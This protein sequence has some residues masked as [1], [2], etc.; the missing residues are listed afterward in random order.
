M[1]LSYSAFAEQSPFSH[2]VIIKRSTKDTKFQ[3]ATDKIYE[4]YKNAPLTN[5]PVDNYS[6]TS[7]ADTVK[8][9]PKNSIYDYI[10]IMLENDPDFRYIHVAPI[11]DDM[12]TAPKVVPKLSVAKSKAFIRPSPIPQKSMFSS[13]SPL[14]NQNAS[15]SSSSVRNNNININNIVNSGSEEDEIEMENVSIANVNQSNGQSK[16]RIPF[17]IR[18]IFPDMISDAMKIIDTAEDDNAITMTES[19]DS[20]IRNIATKAGVNERVVDQIEN[21]YADELT[22]DVLVAY[23]TKTLINN[24]NVAQISRLNDEKI[25]QLALLISTAVSEYKF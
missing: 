5:V 8:Q 6:I 14:S 21:S 15:N 22:A 18:D 17:A 13:E 23:L 1:E 20:I 12:I 4:Y 25:N 24:T 2:L 11:N 19:V 3:K 7:L 9:L 10:S 16:L